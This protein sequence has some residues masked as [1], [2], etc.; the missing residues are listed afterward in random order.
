MRTP[1]R[2][3]CGPALAAL[4]A[5]FIIF[6]VV[7]P[8]SALTAE[9]RVYPNGTAY[10]ASVQFEDA[11]QYEFNEVGVMGE[12]VPLSVGNVQLA[13]PTCSNCSFNWSGSSKITFP[14]GNYTVSFIGPLHDS[15]IQEV[16]TKPYHVNITLPQE[17]DVRNPLLAGI[18]LGANVTRYPDNTTTIQWDNVTSIDLR[19]YDQ[20]REQLL[21]L[22]GNFWIVIAIVL[23]L[24]Y[25]MT[26]RKKE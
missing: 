16:Y 2:N 8:A 25:L 22:F 14:E 13:G 6:L 3:R 15:H 26:M 11:S 9:Y 10:Q 7:L 24:P 18:S 1:D 5:A 12:R 4:C 23:L 17:F 20:G 21:Y 19:F